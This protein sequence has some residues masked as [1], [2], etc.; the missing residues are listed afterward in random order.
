MKNI[1]RKKETTETIL[2]PFTGN[3]IKMEDVPDDVFSQKLMGDGIAI[4]PTEGIVVAPIDGEVIQFFHTKHAIGIRS[5]NGLEVLIHIGLE[6]VA[7]HGEGFEGFVKKG[8]HIK[9]GDKLITFDLGQ[10]KVKA[11]SIISPVVITNGDMVTSLIKSDEKMVTY[12]KSALLIV[13]TK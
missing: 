7:L 11:D 6:T 4:E 12:G 13:K 3:V 2:S 5:T 8:D 9:A 10:I 1:F